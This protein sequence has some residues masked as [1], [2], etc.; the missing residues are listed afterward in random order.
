[1]SNV[2]ELKSFEFKDTTKQYKVDQIV[3]HQRNISS[4]TVDYSVMLDRL[5]R[6]ALAFQGVSETKGKTREA[7]IIACQNELNKLIERVKEKVA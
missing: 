3:Y 1:M 5:N 7:K 6:I 4:D 2:I